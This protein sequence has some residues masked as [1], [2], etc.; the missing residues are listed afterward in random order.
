[1]LATI[2]SKFQVP[3]APLSQKVVGDLTATISEAEAEAQYAA[4]AEEER[5]RYPP[6]SP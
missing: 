1:V 3:Q 6:V 4:F 5:S 2:E